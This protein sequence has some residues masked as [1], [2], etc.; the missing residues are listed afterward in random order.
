MI[1]KYTPYI[2]RKWEDTSSQ[3]LLKKFECIDSQINQ[4]R[5]K[6]STYTSSFENSPLL[7][8]NNDNSVPWR[9]SFRIEG[10]DRNVQ[11]KISNE[12][13]SHNIDV[14]N[15]Y[16]PA[17]WLFKKNTQDN[18]LNNTEKLSSEIFQFW[19]DD[20]ISVSIIKKNIV[21]IKKVISQ[22]VN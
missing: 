15:W 7:P 12:I 4:R 13:R 10:L 16:L 14:S 8:M 22:Y 3:I 21:I 1:Q 19:I 6:V 18:K 11:E 20:S 9:A 5:E 17:H 2:I